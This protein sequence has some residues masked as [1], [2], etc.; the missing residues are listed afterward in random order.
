ME[1]LAHSQCSEDVVFLGI[2]RVVEEILEKKPK[3]R[4]VINS[5]FPMASLRTH[6]YH[7]AFKTVEKYRAP[8]FAGQPSQERVTR[9]GGGRRILSEWDGEL[10]VN[11]TPTQRRRL[12]ARQ[13]TAKE[14][15]R[16]WREVNRNSNRG[17]RTSTRT[18][19]RL[20]RP[21]PLLDADKHKIRK[22]DALRGFMKKK[23]IPL[24]TS[25]NAINNALRKFA[26][27]NSRVSFF[28]S[29]PLFTEK[30]D[31]SKIVMLS[32]LI[33][34]EGRLTPQGYGKWLQHVSQRLEIILKELR[35]THPELFATSMEDGTSGYSEMTDEMVKGIQN[36]EAD[37]Y[38]INY[39]DMFDDGF[40]GGN[41][42]A[43][44][45]DDDT[46]G[47]EENGNDDDDDDDDSTPAQEENEDAG[48]PPEDASSPNANADGN[49]EGDSGQDEKAVDEAGAGASEGI[50]EPTGDADEGKKEGPN[51]ENVAG[52]EKKEDPKAETGAEAGASPTKEETK[53]EEKSEPAKDGGGG[54]E[55]K[56]A[57]DAANKADVDA[58]ATPSADKN[59]KA[60][61]SPKNEKKGEEKGD[62]A[63]AEK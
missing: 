52:G 6:D 13:P 21:D 48:N 58:K 22:Y 42:D 37:L 34:R 55:T 31:K 61:D 59:A 3:A 54:G 30:R 12:Q 16:E 9:T 27:R 44:D 63:N 60:E 19:G 46:V 20:K 7:E 38:D 29:T 49:E 17:S 8:S 5:I 51:A 18:E 10:D 62:T 45:D 24:W 40:D 39:S 28:D 43:V 56:K 4:I 14:E 1:D 26:D 50:P 15:R 57:D 53:A 23:E 36:H 32:S 25:I 35:Q 33:T 2:L 47:A 11:P 41:D